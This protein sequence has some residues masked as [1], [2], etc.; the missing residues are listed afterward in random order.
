MKAWWAGERAGRVAES[1]LPNRELDALIV[2]GTTFAL[3]RLRLSVDT[4]FW[5]VLSHLV[6]ASLSEDKYGVVQRDIPR[7][8]EALTTMTD[9]Q[10]CGEGSD[11]AAKA[12]DLVVQGAHVQDLG[13]PA[14]NPPE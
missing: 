10:L 3:L 13:I 14:C 2:D 12:K 5:A 1:V 8:L 6:C 4:L 11:L 7:V 9:R